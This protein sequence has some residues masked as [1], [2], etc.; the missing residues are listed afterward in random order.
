M[1]KMHKT[2]VLKCIAAVFDVCVHSNGFECYTN[3]CLVPMRLFN[4]NGA[5]SFAFN[6]CESNCFIAQ[7]KGSGRPRVREKPTRI[8]FISD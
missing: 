7:K 1:L 6:P 4:K 3:I 5:R 8:T 2:K